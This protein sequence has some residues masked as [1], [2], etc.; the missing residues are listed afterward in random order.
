MDSQNVNLF[1][2]YPIV[3]I[4][5]L[6]IILLYLVLKAIEV[7]RYLNYGRLNEKI[8]GELKECKWK[9]TYYVQE[10]VKK[11]TCVRPRLKLNRDNK[12]CPQN[13]CR[14]RKFETLPKYEEMRIIKYIDQI[15]AIFASLYALFKVVLEIYKCFF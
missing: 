9:K 7:I 13:N 3:S 5:V 8:R 10:G 1:E 15:L 12:G 4:I 6:V 11:Y 14:H 2:Q